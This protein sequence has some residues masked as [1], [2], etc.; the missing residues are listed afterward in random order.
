MFTSHA[1][2]KRY[3]LTLQ[4]PHATVH[5]SEVAD[6][7][8]A[9]HSMPA[10]TRATWSLAPTSNHLRP[11]VALPTREDMTGEGVVVML[12]I[13]PWSGSCGVRRLGRKLREQWLSVHLP[14]T[15]MRWSTYDNFVCRSGG[16][17]VKIQKMLRISSAWHFSLSILFQASSYRW[18]YFFHFKN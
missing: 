8:L 16:V 15:V 13:A 9:W 17:S 11:P 12:A 6:A 14:T 7:W 5:S 1:G 4:T 18:Y 3:C 2:R 10:G